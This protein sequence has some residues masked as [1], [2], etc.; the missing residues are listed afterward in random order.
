M[1]LEEIFEAA[2]RHAER[3][4]EG[5][6]NAS[7]QTRQNLRSLR[8]K[9]IIGEEECLELLEVLETRAREKECAYAGI[10]FHGWMYNVSCCMRSRGDHSSAYV[11]E[12]ECERL[13][14]P[15]SPESAIGILKKLRMGM[16]YGNPY[17]E[18]VFG[19][20]WGFVIPARERLALR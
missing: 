4:W 9:A 7:A 19:I 12:K 20:K 18:K 8:E 3:F 11:L 6:D 13:F 14:D 5:L 2:Y 15:F 10:P 1:K 16:Y 17:F